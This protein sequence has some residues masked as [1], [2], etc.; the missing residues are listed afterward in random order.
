NLDPMS[1]RRMNVRRLAPAVALLALSSIAYAEDVGSIPT[2]KTH[3][4]GR[5]DGFHWGTPE[6]PPA[7]GPTAA[8]PPAA[9]PAV[10]PK[11][12]TPAEAAIKRLAT[13]PGQDGIKAAES[14]LLMGPE[15]VEPCA[16]AVAKG[17]AASKPGAAWVL[18]KIGSSSHVATIM[19]AAAE[20]TSG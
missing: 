20:R 2:T 14:L 5:D 15:A 11:V 10:P 13:W 4:K 16:H 6:E 17:D 9:A 1:L 7:T 19:I 18:G 12:L 3:P 8:P